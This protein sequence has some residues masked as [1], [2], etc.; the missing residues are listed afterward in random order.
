M[1]RHLIYAALFPLALAADPPAPSIRLPAPDA[2]P[3][4]AP[5]PMPGPDAPRNKLLP[6]YRFVIDSPVEC[7]VRCHPAGLV[8]VAKKK[9]PR[10][11]SAKFVGGPDDIVDKSFD[12]PFLYVVSGTHTGVVEIDIVPVGFKLE[13]EIT[14]FKL[15]VDAGEG[16]RPPP[17][18][19]PPT[20]VG[21]DALPAGK[22]LMVKVVDE[23]KTWTPARADLFADLD[24]RRQVAAITGADLE[25]VRPGSD[26]AAAMNLAPFVAKAG[27]GPTLIVLDADGT[28]KGVVR[29]AV[30]LP[31]SKAAILA[32]LNKLY[33]K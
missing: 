10:D 2:A 32:A 23:T 33:G 27:G 8:V 6:G 11:I 1:L 5:A 25:I 21:P 17:I 12:G 19:V 30:P 15:D 26:E 22:K 9:G 16:P 31:D 29:L 7:V 13:A 28:N 3:A 14:S 18:V 20:P 4:P 24:L